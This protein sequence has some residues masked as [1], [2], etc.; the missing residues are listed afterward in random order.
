MLDFEEFK[1][2]SWQSGV[3]AAVLTVAAVVVVLLTAPGGRGPAVTA[4]LAGLVAGLM[5][6]AASLT[7][8]FHWLTTPS[9]RLGWTVAA[10]VVMGTQVVVSSGYN[11]SVLSQDR[12]LFATSGVGYDILAPAVVLGLVALGARGLPMPIPLGLG[13]G[14]GITLA[15]LNVTGHLDPLVS[16]SSRPAAL[17]AS[18]MVLCGYLAVAGLVLRDIG[19]VQWARRRLA[20][21]ITLIAFGNAVRAWPGHVDATDLFTACMQVGA[22]AL[23]AGASF[24]LLREALVWQ[25]RRMVALEDSMLEVESTV[26]HSHETLHEIRST[27]VG[28]ASASRLLHDASPG[29]SA[30]AR[31]ERAIS[32]ELDRLERLVVGDSSHPPGPVDVDATLDVLLESHRAQGRTIEWEPSGAVVHARPDVV[33]EA[34]NILLDNAA[35]HG[36]SRSRI[37]VSSAEDVV[38]I[39]VTDEGPGVP[40]EARDQIFE[41]GVHRSESPGQ[42]IGLNLARRLVAEHGGS[43]VLADSDASSGSSFVIRLPRGRLQEGASVSDARRSS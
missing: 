33:A 34:L 41:W 39:A 7:F 35:V 2:S 10:M 25:H 37:A 29:S 9:R 6:L 40:P 38:E 42:G 16:V 26:R 31:L 13:L 4:L 17:A 8:Y 22:A 32:T 3:L 24:R 19:L 18:L 36:G 1:R 20:T 11:L 43:L 15:A 12:N 30:H 14:A 23:W 28:A 21:A 5:L 27:V